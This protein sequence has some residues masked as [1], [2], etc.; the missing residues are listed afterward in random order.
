MARGT[1]GLIAL[2]ILVALVVYFVMEERDEDLEIDV[3]TLDVPVHVLGSTPA[4]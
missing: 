4:L 2:I 1:L 3:G